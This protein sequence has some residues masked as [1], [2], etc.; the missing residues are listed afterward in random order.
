M[1]QSVCCVTAQYRMNPLLAELMV[2][3]G[4][5]ERG[6]PAA[7]DTQPVIFLHGSQEELAEDK[8]PELYEAKERLYDPLRPPDLL[9][10]SKAGGLSG[11]YNRFF[12]SYNSG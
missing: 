4:R 12:A 2:A 3:P 10:P 6:N 8:F 1:L 9:Q 11:S 5:L 7:S